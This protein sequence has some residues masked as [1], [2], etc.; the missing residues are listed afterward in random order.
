MFTLLELSLVLVER[1]GEQSLFVLSAEGLVSEGAIL[2][3]A[4]LLA[5][6]GLD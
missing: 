2:G 3:G 5:G 1:T 4:V 6:A